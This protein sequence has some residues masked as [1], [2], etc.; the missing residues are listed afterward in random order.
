MGTSNTC[1]EGVRGGFGY[2]SRNQDGE[3]VLSFALAYNM[4]VA[5][6]LFRKRE[7]HLVTS[8]S[9]QHSSHIDLVLSRRE[10]KR[11]CLDCKDM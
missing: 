11:A 8:S 1:F 5:N 10:D 9:R 7:Y 6:I 3:D 2:G 4:T